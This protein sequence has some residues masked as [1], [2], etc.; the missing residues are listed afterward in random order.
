MPDV[1]YT[2]HVPHPDEGRHGVLLVEPDTDSV[3]VQTFSREGTLLHEA[4]LDVL[5]WEE[6]IRERGAVITPLIR[7]LGAAVR[8]QRDD[9]SQSIGVLIPHAEG[10]RALLSAENRSYKALITRELDAAE[11]F[12]LDVLKT[13]LIPVGEVLYL[14]M[15]VLPLHDGRACVVVTCAAGQVLE[16]E[17]YRA[18]GSGN[19]VLYTRL[20]VP[21]V[22]CPEVGKLYVTCLHQ[23]RS[24]RG[25]SIKSATAIT[26]AVNPWDVQ[27]A[28]LYLGPPGSVVKHLQ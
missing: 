25:K 12:F 3:T 21:H 22:R 4:A 18:Q 11:L 28:S 17:R 6:T 2:F 14:D 5:E 13:A 9:G 15:Q 16:D 19:R 20:N 26:L 27:L 23:P 1:A 10:Q 8:V 24:S 7:R